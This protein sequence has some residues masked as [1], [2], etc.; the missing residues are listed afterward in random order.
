VAEV[1]RVQIQENKARSAG[2]S[3][4]EMGLRS[5]GRCDVV[6]WGKAL[7]HTVRA[8]IPGPFFVLLLIHPLSVSPSDMLLTML[9]RRR[10]D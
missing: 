9:Q 6:E 2:L 5:H 10:R 8:P 4:E 1:V 3:H 7:L